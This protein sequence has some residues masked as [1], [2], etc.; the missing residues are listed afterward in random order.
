M[1]DPLYYLA[2]ECGLVLGA[3]A[4]VWSDP[5]VSGVQEPKKCTCKNKNIDEKEWVQTPW[6][7]AGF[8]GSVSMMIF[9]LKMC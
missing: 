4:W 5:F 6:A 2:T 9:S 1:Y 3:V 7:V 8:T